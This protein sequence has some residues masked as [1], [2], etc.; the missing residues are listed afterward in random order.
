MDLRSTEIVC[1]LRVCKEG[2]PLYSPKGDTMTTIDMTVAS[3]RRYVQL[4]SLKGVL[5]LKKVGLSVRGV[6]SPLA[7]AKSL[8]YTGPRSIDAAYGWT[9]AQMD[10]MEAAREHGE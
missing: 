10:Q 7:V 8:G 4:A 9:V 1:R 3:N 6:G 2:P 5:R